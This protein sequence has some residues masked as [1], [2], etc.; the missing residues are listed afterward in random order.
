MG[1]T[2]LLDT[3]VL[4]WLLAAPEKIPADVRGTLA[5]GTT[6][7]LA[8]SVSA[9]EVATKARHGRLPGADSLVATWQ[10]RLA[11]L[12]IGELS[13]TT[14]HALLAGSMAWEHRDP[15]D[16][17]LVAQ[18]LVENLTLVTVDAEIRG[19]AGLRTLTWTSRG[20]PGGT[21]G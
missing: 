21:P 9:M 17:L 13:L 1:V 10:A 15:F 14:A 6:T 18:T 19:V 16:R 2:Y 5:A 3:H 7:L 20:L 11:D 4:L 8:S 12:R